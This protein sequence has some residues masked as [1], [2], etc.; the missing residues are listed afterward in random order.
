M[1]VIS[2]FFNMFQTKVEIPVSKLKIDYEDKIM[3]LGSCFAQNIGKKMEEVWFDTIINP[4]GVLYNPVSIQKSIELL[5]ENK[6]FTENDL[7]DYRGLWQSFSQSSLFSDITA[8]KCLIKI[9]ERYIP[10]RDFLK[11]TDFLLITFGTSWVF[12]EKKT[13]NIVSNC[14][15]LPANDFVRRRLTVEEIVSLYTKLFAKLRELFPKLKLVFSV[16]PIRH[17]KDGAHENNVSKSI[18]LLAI[19]QLQK[20]FENV[21]YFP[22]YEIQMDELRDYRFYA[23]DMFHPSDVA[24]DYIWKRFSETYFDNK[25]LKI[26]KELEQLYADLS[27][28]PLQPN[29]EEFLLFQKNIENRKMKICT[30][31]PFLKDKIQ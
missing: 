22:A 31:Y 4:F 6:T 15:K 8:E 29:S 21:E 5:I 23:S 12:E 26:K 28:R 17:W 20:Q 9:N 25:T 16:S 13:G 3:T 30:E 27:H 24:V 10:A 1:L 11:K 14:H 2:S 18:L 19:E 7:F